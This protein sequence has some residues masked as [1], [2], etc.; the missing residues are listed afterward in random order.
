MAAGSGLVRAAPT[1]L[2]AVIQAVNALLS[3]ARGGPGPVDALGSPTNGQT[4]LGS[5]ANKWRQIF[6]SSLVLDGN[7]LTGAQISVLRTRGFLFFRGPIHGQAPGS[8]NVRQMIGDAATTVSVLLQPPGGGNGGGGGGSAGAVLAP[9]SG[10]PRVAGFGGGSG[11]QG[12]Q[13][14]PEGLIFSLQPAQ[15]MVITIE[16]PG[17]GGLGGSGT[18]FPTYRVASGTDALDGNSGNPGNQG[19]S[20][21]VSVGATN[22]VFR[23]GYGGAGGRGGRGSGVRAPSNTI[24]AGRGGDGWQGGGDPVRETAQGV[25]ASVDE[26]TAGTNWAAHIIGDT[27][28]PHSNG[29]RSPVVGASGA[30]GAGGQG[31]TA[32]TGGSAGNAGSNGLPGWAL[33]VGWS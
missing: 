5:A 6:A 3:W 31:G 8:F 32:T 30:A 25:F 21:T 17:L 10:Y 12:Q 13:P 20:I 26:G 18:V 22:T 1:T 29:G 33:V 9:G 24:S 14:P 23:G 27:A 28:P 19:G 16:A 4:D 7:V 11:G 15:A 2:A